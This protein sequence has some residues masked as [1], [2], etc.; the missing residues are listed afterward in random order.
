V[1]GSLLPL[2]AG[3]D[4]LERLGVLVREYRPREV[5]VLGD[6]VQRAHSIEPIREELRRLCRVCTEEPETRLQL[7]AGNHDRALAGLLRECEI[8]LPLAAEHRL[9]GHLFLHGD[10]TPKEHEH[11]IEGLTF[12][13][14]EHPS[15]TLGDGIASVKC[16]CFLVAAGLVVLPAFSAW[17]AGSDVRAG[18]FLSPLSKAAKFTRAVAIL[19]GKLLPMPL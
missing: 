6:I 4:T 13:G 5:I 17:A 14:H 8:A 3:D 16:P 10:R 11:A 7:I 15:L 12:I 18:C 1:E 9:G 19:A 2:S